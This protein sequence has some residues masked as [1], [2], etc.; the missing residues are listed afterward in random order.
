VQWVAL[1][2]GAVDEGAGVALI[3]V[4]DQVL[5]LVLGPAQE[6][7][8]AAGGEGGAAAAPE[9]GVGHF[10]DDAFGRGGQRLGQTLV[11]AAADVLVD[12]LRLDDAAVGHQSPCLKGDDVEGLERRQ[13]LHRRQPDGRQSQHPA[14]ALA[15][16]GFV[17]ELRHTVGSDML[18]EHAL[19]AGLGDLQHGLCVAE[20]PAACD[21]DVHGQVAL[22]HLAP[23]G[24][25]RLVGALGAAAGSNAHG[26]ARPGR[27]LH[28]PPHLVGLGP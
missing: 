25:Q 20:A 3:G 27:L 26:D 19:A 8:L 12:A 28:R 13:A 24:G 15:V 5:R 22:G 11:T 9:T 7:P 2:E 14:N 17:D 10:F 16:E 1:H 6:V 23:D 21:H 18:I 4:A